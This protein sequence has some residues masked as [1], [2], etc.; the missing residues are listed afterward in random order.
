[1]RI[2]VIAVLVVTVLMSGFS[3]AKA[4]TS[5]TTILSGGGSL[6][7]NY[8]ISK[9]EADTTDYWSSGA[10]AFLSIRHSR[11]GAKGRLLLGYGANYR[12]NIRDGTSEWSDHRF[13]LSGSRNLSS[14][15][16]F[17][18]N[19]TFIM[20]NDLWG[21][22]ISS[23]ATG[24]PEPDDFPDDEETPKPVFGE[25]AEQGDP[26]FSVKIGQE[27]FWSNSFSTNLRMYIIVPFIFIKSYLNSTCSELI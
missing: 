6:R 25:A 2:T 13:N 24:I 20:T 17:N 22:N 9:N 1:M 7:A 19:N 16:R 10:N 15:L 23:T 26:D 14:R 18:L 4:E 3:V 21:E 27:K 8:N 5:A 11:E 12:Y